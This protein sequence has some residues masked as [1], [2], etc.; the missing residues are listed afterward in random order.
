MVETNVLGTK[1]L[2]NLAVG[3]V[4]RFVLL[5]STGVYGAVSDTMVTEETQPTP[6]NPYEISKLEADKIARQIAITN[7]LSLVII[8]PSNIYGN[9]MTNQSLFGLIKA[10]QRNLFFFM[11]PKGAIAN[12]IHVDNVI[13]ALVLAGSANHI[14]N[15]SIYN[16]SD[17]CTVEELIGYIAAALNKECPRIRLPLSLVRMLATVL[18]KS[19]KSPLTNSRVDALT[20]KTIYNAD[21]IKLEL[22]YQHEIS[23][24][25]GIKDLTQY[26]LNGF[27]QTH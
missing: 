16:V 17:H 1:N 21:K 9:T 7:G 13:H 24:E 26:L 8:R 10:V 4:K 18:Q 6:N 15:A 19:K 22:G 14:T 27:S 25:Q 20:S 5:S 23:I 11:G 12:Y 2:V 3:R